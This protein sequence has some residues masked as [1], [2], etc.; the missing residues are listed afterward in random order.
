M[1]SKVKLVNIPVADQDRAVAFYCDVLGFTKLADFPAGPDQRWIE[2][3]ARNGGAK[4]VLFAPDECDLHPGRFMN[5]VFTSD[6]VAGEYARLRAA[7]VTFVQELKEAEWGSS[8]IFRDSE[9][10]SFALTTDN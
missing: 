9:G 7:G 2:L 4:V 3:G 8:F 6:D 5:V 1:I 10:N